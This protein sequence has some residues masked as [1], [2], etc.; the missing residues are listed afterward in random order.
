MKP[1][2]ESVAFI[3]CALTR[4]RKL[5]LKGTHR[6][7]YLVGPYAIKRPVF[8]PWRLFLCGLL[9]NMQEATFSDAG[10]SELCPVVFA[11]PGGWFNIMRRAEPITNEQFAKLNYSEWIRG[12]Q[13]L[14]DGDWIIPV[15]NKQCS[16]GILDGRIV[17]VDYGS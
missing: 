14:P 17:A 15:E 13:A 9:A 10:W 4:W 16:F 6:V 12:G 3:S 11:M 8:R 5:R 1:N 2:V 7:V